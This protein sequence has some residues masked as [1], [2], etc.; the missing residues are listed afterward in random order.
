MLFEH[1]TGHNQLQ[2]V[3]NK[4]EELSETQL[5]ALKKYADALANGKPIQYILGK[6]GLWVRNMSLMIRY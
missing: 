4:N 6:A 2:Q 3:I 5:I 1:V